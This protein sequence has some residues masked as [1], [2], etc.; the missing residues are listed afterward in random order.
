MRSTACTSAKNAM[1]LAAARTHQAVTRWGKGLVA[2]PGTRKEVEAIGDCVIVGSKATESAL[3]RAL[4]ERKRWRA[5]HLACHGLI[6]SR[7]PMF[8]ALALTP[9]PSDD[10]LLTAIRYDNWKVVFYEQRTQGTLQIWAEPFVELRVP[11][12]FNLR[13]DP[14]ERA[15]ITSNTYYDW[16]LD[17][18]W[19]LVPAQAYV[20]EMMQT[21]V[22]FPPRQEPAAFNVSKVMD[23]LQAGVSS[24]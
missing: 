22:E 20:A 15:D 24:A 1:R 18:A 13:T 5:V 11:K 14:F 3:S 17:R 21:L 7:R 8:S 16:L 6:D 12:I 4:P 23:K 10:G 19:V 9:G 2:L